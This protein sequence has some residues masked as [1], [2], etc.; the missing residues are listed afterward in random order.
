[1]LI[2]SAMRSATNDS[3]SVAGKVVAISCVTGAPE[4]MERPRSPCRT[5]PSHMPYCA[6]SERSSPMA[7]RKASTSARVALGGSIMPSGSAGS[8]R[9]TTNTTT[10]SAN[11]VGTA[12]ARRRAK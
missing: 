11:M 12:T 4:L 10:D 7:W 5:C 8:S 9:S 2:A 3:S 6:T 1:M